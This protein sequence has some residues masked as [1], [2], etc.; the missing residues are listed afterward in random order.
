MVTLSFVDA[1]TCV[2]FTGNPAAVCLLPQWPAADWMQSV[3]AEINLSETVFVVAQEGGYGIRWFTP[4][5]EVELC[6]HAT[7]AAAHLLDQIHITFFS[8]SGVLKAE[9]L[10]DGW[11]RLDFPSYQAQ[12]CA[13]PAGLLE[14]LGCAADWLGCKQ[15][16]FLVV[17]SHESIV[18]GL[19]PDY[20]VL[21]R[22]PIRDVIVTSPG[23]RHCHSSCLLEQANPPSSWTGQ[24]FDCVSRVF[25]PG[26]GIVEDPVTGSAHCLIGPYWARR[27]GK[28]RLLAYQAS[29][30]GGC[31]RLHYCGPRT[32]LEGQ[33]VTVARVELLV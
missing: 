12:P 1:F 31:L 9:R 26:S 25:A 33:A 11:I 27:L 29:A 20:G 17:V 32:F 19:R 22:L 13:P 23:Q 8:R 3:A 28:S 5:I 14:A 15:Q 21:A 2:P 18:R 16:D 24:E 6:G 30:R 10:S 7:L 4:T